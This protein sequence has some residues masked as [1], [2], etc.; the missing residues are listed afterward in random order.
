M[1][2][3]YRQLRIIL[4]ILFLPFLGKGQ[5]PAQVYR[6]FIRHNSFPLGIEH[7]VL[8]SDGIFFYAN[9]AD[10]KVFLAKGTWKI[11]QN[12]LYLNGWD[13]SK[14]YPKA[15][16]DFVKGDK[17]EEVI[18]LVKDYFKNPFPGFAIDLIP[19]Q[20]IGDPN[21]LRRMLFSDS[22]GKIKLSKKDYSAFYFV[23]M[24][25]NS[26]LPAEDVEFY[27]LTEDISRV[28]ISIDFAGN[29]GLDRGAAL[30]KINA[31]F[32]LKKN[33]L[34]EKDKLVYKILKK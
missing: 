16:I 2:E 11:R 21:G 23:Y 31:V 9:S 34:Y 1:S 15:K 3:Y 19:G 33:G 12:Q 13:S 32:T 14:A 18:I 10:E 20:A 8:G 27:N 24:S 5:K 26:E 29:A 30:R 4:V 7:I 25:Y 28:N 22:S 6:S 17:T